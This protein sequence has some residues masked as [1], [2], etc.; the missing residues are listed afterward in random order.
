MNLA[1]TRLTRT[2][3]VALTIFGAVAIPLGTAPL[4]AAAGT[5]SGLAKSYTGSA[6]NLT[7]A[8]SGPI[9]LSGVTQT[10]GA[11]SGTFRVPRAPDRNGALHRDDYEQSR[12]LHGEAHGCL[13]P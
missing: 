12:F 10:G 7:A 11:I 6:K 13:V 3:A 4:A 9:N 2:F 5:A 1:G 8:E